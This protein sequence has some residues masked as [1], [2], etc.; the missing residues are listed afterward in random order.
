MA[1]VIEDVIKGS[2]SDKNGV[3]SADILVSINGNE[4]SDVLDYRFY[5]T[6]KLITLKLLRSENQSYEVTIKKNEYDD[7][8]L[9]FKTYL[10]DSQR[11]CKNGCIFCFIDQN[12]KGM[13]ES[14]YFKDD[15]DRMSFL[16]GNYITLTNLEEKDIDRIIKMKISPINISVHT[17]NPELRVKMMKNRFS[18][19]VLK[20]LKRLLEAGIAVN[21][22]LVLCPNI[23]DGE[24][25]RNTLSELC[26]YAPQIGSICCVPVGLTAY[27]EGLYPLSP[28]DEKSSA[29]VIDIIHEFSDKLL[30]EHG[31]R[32]V[33][34]SDEFF[35]KA[36]RDIPPAEYYGDFKQLENGVGIT[37]LLRK[38][39]IEELSYT[40]P[41]NK[42]R[43]ISIA[44]G[45]AA[46]TFIKEL[47]EKAE[48]L[49]PSLTTNVY[50][51]PSLFFGGHITVTG[52]VCGSDLQKELADKSLGDTLLIPDV[53]LRHEGD[54]FLDN[55]STEDIEASF[56]NTKVKFIGTDGMTL[57]EML[58]SED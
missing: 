35:I 48:E 21:T 3:K 10:M 55:V 41:L 50:A 5:I 37:A 46:Y 12:P 6:E 23:N 53:M 33:Y 58:F 2:L 14:I 29:E 49:D 32:I 20:Y 28:F 45:K 51:I 22:Q 56:E 25:L 31:D 40:N 7:I 4:I 19:D 42:N 44:T 38:D 34:P 36:K 26:S 11:S 52:L 9:E 18:G 13:R 1:V 39:F 43:T 30:L 54:L 47:C 24:E 17:T 16:M 27:R 57:C 15:D 8:G